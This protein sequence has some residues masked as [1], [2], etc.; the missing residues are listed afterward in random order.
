MARI[1]TKTKDRYRDTMR[2]VIQKLSR[3]VLVYMQ[4]I[5]SECPNCYYDKLTDKSTGKCR[6][7]IAEVL[8]KNDPTRYKYF[9]LGRCPICNSK[10]YLEVQRKSWCDCLVSWDPAQ[11]GTGNT[12][13]Q[14]PAGT[15]GSTVVQ[16]KTHPRNYDLFK[17]C[18]KIIIDG[19]TCKLSRPPMLRGLGNQS[20]LLI[21]AFT[22][23]K[24]KIDSDEIIK[25]YT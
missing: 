19:V 10:G 4:S 17:N 8:A 14:T 15:E 13:I 21:S 7:T 18:S 22:T 12:V 1:G 11:R 16:L 3:K 9:R 5:K 23:E 25:D 20:I 6:W 24:P 2:D